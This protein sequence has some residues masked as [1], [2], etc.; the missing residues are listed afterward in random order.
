MTA[1][2]VHWRVRTELGVTPTLNV[3]IQPAQLAIATLE[4]FVE[5]TGVFA[6]AI[7]GYVQEINRRGVSVRLKSDRDVAERLFL[8]L[9]Q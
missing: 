2:H 5:L 8:L 4:Y 3:S 7:N 6:P 9:L 1:R